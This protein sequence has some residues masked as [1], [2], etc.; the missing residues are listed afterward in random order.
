MC[1]GFQIYLSVW[2]L[3]ILKHKSAH[4]SDLNA[5]LPL[6]TPP[7]LLLHIWAIHMQYSSFLRTKCGAVENVSDFYVRKCSVNSDRFH[8]AVEKANIG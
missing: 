2:M 4:A 1:V 5:N 6:N 8:S 7:Q 3:K